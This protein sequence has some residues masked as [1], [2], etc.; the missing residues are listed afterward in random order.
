MLHN[1]VQL[2]IMNRWEEIIKA[3]SNHQTSTF[4]KK[5]KLRE[6]KEMVYMPI[7]GRR[8]QKCKF[9]CDLCECFPRLQL[10]ASHLSL[11]GC[12][13]IIPVAKIHIITIAISLWEY[14][15]ASFVP[16]QLNSCVF[17]LKKCLL[18]VS[19]TSRKYNEDRVWD[20]Y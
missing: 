9:L 20:Y 5:K 3:T 8:W 19:N 15:W 4:N 1:L 18:T 12:M 7:E 6:R 10:A 16:H 17:K 14:C 13:F 11:W 2:F